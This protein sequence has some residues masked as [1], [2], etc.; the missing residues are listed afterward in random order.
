ML[1]QG[2]LRFIRAQGGL[3]SEAL[4]G[5]LLEGLRRNEGQINGGD[6]LGGKAGLVGQFGQLWLTAQAGTQTLAGGPKGLALFPQ[7]TT[8]LDWAVIPEKAAD[9]AGDL[10]DSVG[11]ELRSIR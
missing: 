4:G 5:L 2:R 1:H 11:G 10:G 7:G 8:H 9:L 3:Q 6:L